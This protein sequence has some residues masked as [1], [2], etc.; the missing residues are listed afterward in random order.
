MKWKKEPKDR[1]FKIIQLG[2]PKIKNKK[3][4][5]RHIG[6]IGHHQVYMCMFHRVTGKRDDSIFK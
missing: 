1:P 2:E 5:K 6:L 4:E 3:S